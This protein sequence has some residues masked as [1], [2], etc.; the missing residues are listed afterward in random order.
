MS[1]FKLVST[2]RSTPSD[3]SSLFKVLVP[4]KLWASLIFAIK[5]RSVSVAAYSTALNG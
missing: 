4:G 5:A 3:S 2:R 1:R